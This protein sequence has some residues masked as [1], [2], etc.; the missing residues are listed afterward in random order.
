MRAYRVR[1]YSREIVQAVVA[2]QAERSSPSAE[3][4]LYTPANYSESDDD[5]TDIEDSLMDLDDDDDFDWDDD[6]DESDLYSTAMEGDAGDHIMDARDALHGPIQIP[7]LPMIPFVDPPLMAPQLPRLSSIRVPHLE[8]CPL[9]TPEGKTYMGRGTPIDRQ[10][11]QDWA[12]IRPGPFSYMTQDWLSM[13]LPPSPNPSLPPSSIQMPLNPESSYGVP[14][15]VGPFSCTEQG[16]FGA[17]GQLLSSYTT[18]ASQP[19]PVSYPMPVPEPAS[20]RAWLD[21]TLRSALTSPLVPALLPLEQEPAAP[22]PN[23][24]T[25]STTE[26][27]LTNSAQHWTGCAWHSTLMQCLLASGCMPADNVDASSSPSASPL[28]PL[29]STDV[30]PFR[31]PVEPESTLSHALG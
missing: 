15:E 29:G 13:F 23:F 7:S 16:T 2:A 28:Q 17:G 9:L 12:N 3:F 24:T 11:R 27:G 4:L 31:E 19:T 6:E 14:A 22:L 5:F 8:P 26:D 1:R 20:E 10:R 25:T 30:Y 18:Q 21:P